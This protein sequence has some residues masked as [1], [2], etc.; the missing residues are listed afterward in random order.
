LQNDNKEVINTEETKTKEKPN[1]F[2]WLFESFIWLAVILFIIDVT[3]KFIAYYNLSTTTSTVVPG[4]TW[5]FQLTLTFNTGAAWGFGGDSLVGQILLCILSYAAAAIIIIYFVKKQKVLTKTLKA[6]LMV[7][8]AGD[9]GNLIDRTFALMP[10]LPTIYQNGV[11]DFI[12]VTPLIPGFGIFNFAD[13]CLCV[14]ILM[15]V[16]YEIVVSI[17]DDRKES[18]KS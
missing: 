6:I 2:K 15:L 18:K 4:F 3:T 9:M 13:S 12:D 1:F 16:I 7:C 8:L 10:N 11:V 14:G 17:R 5:L